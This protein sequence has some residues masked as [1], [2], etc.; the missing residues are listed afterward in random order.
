LGSESRSFEIKELNESDYEKLSTFMDY[1]SIMKNR[2]Q[3]WILQFYR[4]WI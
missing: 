4:C 2:I 3:C 1:D